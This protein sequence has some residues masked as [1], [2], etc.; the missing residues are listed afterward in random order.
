MLTVKENPRLHCESQYCG[1]SEMATGGSNPVQTM[2]SNV[3]YCNAA[4]LMSSGIRWSKATMTSFTLCDDLSVR[5]GV[6]GAYDSVINRSS[7]CL[8]SD[9]ARLQRDA[10]HILSFT[11]LEVMLV[12]SFNHGAFVNQDISCRNGEGIEEHS[13]E[14]G[15]W[16]T[17]DE[18]ME[19]FMEE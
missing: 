18:D 3:T 4:F 1:L 5:E 9:R 19:E 10:C 11:D 6:A 12:H 14:Y 13:I 8:Q 2:A 16:I 7:I 15:G 17:S